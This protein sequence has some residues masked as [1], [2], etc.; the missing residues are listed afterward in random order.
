MGKNIDLFVDQE[1]HDRIKNLKI[2]FPIF[3]LYKNIRSG[4]TL[5]TERI[6]KNIT[7]NAQALTIEGEIPDKCQVCIIDYE[8]KG[9]LDKLEEILQA[10]KEKL[11]I[12]IDEYTLIRYKKRHDNSSKNKLFN[13][14]LDIFNG[15]EKLKGDDIIEYE[16]KYEEV[17]EIIKDNIQI[18][19]KD[20][21]KE[22]KTVKN[23]S[24]I[25]YDER[26][27]TY[28]L[29]AISELS[30]KF[31]NKE[32]EIES[33]DIEIDKLN[34]HLKAFTAVMGVGLLGEASLYDF[35]ANISATAALPTGLMFAP[36]LL[37]SI[38]FI[39]IIKNKIFPDK[40]KKAETPLQQLAI[41][42]AAWK[43]LPKSSLE[44][45]CYQMD[46]VLDLPLYTTYNNLDDM[47]STRNAEDIKKA[48]DEKLKDE[49]FLSKINEIYLNSEY[50]N[51]L[52]AKLSD[53]TKKIEEYGERINK[54]E[55]E[56]KEIKKTLAAQ[57]QKIETQK[58][59]N[60]TSGCT[61]FKSKENPN[62]IFKD[63]KTLED[64]FTDTAIPKYIEKQ[65]ELIDDIL[66]KA[67]SKLVIINGEPGAGKSILLYQIAK[68]IRNKYEKVFYINEFDKFSPLN[69]SKSNENNYA[70][71]DNI[72]IEK[73]NQII[74]IAGNPGIKRIIL[75][76]RKEYLKDK[77]NNLN[78]D[79]ICL[80]DY[81]P[82]DTFLKILADTLIKKE[83]PDNI[84]LFNEQELIDKLVENSNGIALYISEAVKLLKQNDFST[85]A[86]ENTPKG[87]KDLVNKILEDEIK[88]NPHL[89][90]IYYLVSHYSG[91]PGELLTSI[92]NE[93]P[94]LFKEEPIYL[95]ER[96]GLCYLHSWYKDIT[97]EIFNSDKEPIN[98]INKIHKDLSELKTLIGEIGNVKIKEP[99]SEFLDNIDNGVDIKDLSDLI[100]LYGIKNYA[101]SKKD[102][103]YGFNIITGKNNP[104]SA[105]KYENL[106]KFIS[107]SFINDDILKDLNNRPIYA[108]I[109]LLVCRLLTSNNYI[110]NISEN[111]LKQE[112]D[113]IDFEYVF[114]GLV[115]ENI[116]NYEFIP[117]IIKSIIRIHEQFVND[118]DI[119]NASDYDK[120][121]YSFFTGN[122]NLKL[123]VSLFINKA[124][125]CQPNND[126][127]HFT[128]GFFN[129]I[130]GNK[131]KAIEEYD[132]AIRLLSQNDKK[133]T[134]DNLFYYIWKGFAL[135]GLG[136]CYEAIIP[137]NKAIELDLNNFNACF[138]KGLALYGLNQYEEAIEFFNKAIKLD[139]SNSLVNML[140]GQGLGLLD[141]YEEAFKAFN[142]AIE[143][144]PNNSNAYMGKGNVLKGI[145]KYEDAIKAYDK[146]IELN[147]DNSNAYFN[148]GNLL[149]ILED[150]KHAIKLFNKA[151]ELDPNNSDAY[152]NKG[153]ALNKLEQFEDAIKAFN[154][155]IE[156][157]PNKTDYYIKLL[158]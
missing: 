94:D 63:N 147:P 122:L 33:L 4:K 19:N 20:K 112:T 9:S 67:S 73:I 119:N 91:F 74:D 10:N 79:F 137:I 149:G 21:E 88:R 140:K 46:N 32:V 18:N 13:K 80:Y 108:L 60:T 146:A 23:I 99:L 34:G 49:T 29:G 28:I 100:L 37:M 2:N 43:E 114:K 136:L 47:F 89:I 41:A 27:K 120:S 59:E 111:I 138:Y 116:H 139:P 52:D 12:L 7:P 131:K 123:F 110:K 92:K 58:E 76:T 5:T 125:Q 127:Y 38:P 109:I 48:I 124:L 39:M 70:V 42:V 141:Q 22:K 113:N 144:E 55:R 145:G 96:K 53:I 118:I 154:K 3:V 25:I 148:K 84:K 150:Y 65:Q 132:K 8:P 87:I 157:N 14:I 152:S 106:I 126:F 1:I 6:L 133:D 71:L 15:K 103:K 130:A 17:E 115:S 134:T 69:F 35:I 16:V 11:I 129:Y 105:Y 57:D 45:F 117:N 151:I 62:D 135:I 82:E 93:F 121:I 51:E 85:D 31:K 36:P 153:Y 155:A 104:G 98:R 68:A 54:L 83:K 107:E 95:E 97:D 90:Y 64:Q 78:K 128:N 81:K 26:K 102:N 66:K 158:R 40:L 77:L 50:R 156:L 143:L 142:K 61:K 72:N 86:I 101:Y 24:K 30:E 56:V 44:A 75:T